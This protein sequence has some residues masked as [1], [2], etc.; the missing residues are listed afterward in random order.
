MEK[1]KKLNRIYGF[2]V[3]VERVEQEEVLKTVKRKDPDTKKMVNV[4]IKEMAEKTIKTPFH[5]IM[6]RPTRSII[7]EADLFY[8]VQFNKYVKMGLLTAQQMAK[9]CLDTG[10]VLSESQEKHYAALQTDFMAK[11]EVLVRLISKGD[12]LSEDE[13]ER[14]ARLEAEVANLQ[15]KIGD[16]EYAKNTIMDHTADSKA[17]NDVIRWWVLYLTQYSEGDENDSAVYLDMFGGETY[18]ARREKEEELEDNGD[19]LFDK[20]IQRLVQAATLW[21]WIGMDNEKDIDSALKS[22][23]PEAQEKEDSE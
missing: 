5:V 15:V 16:Y 22:L 8:S 20:C 17:R 21:Y 2:D 23:N 10:G 7:Q 18:S 12:S 6:K 4:E 3:F 9:Q 1:V 13:I 14:K 11:Q 19:P